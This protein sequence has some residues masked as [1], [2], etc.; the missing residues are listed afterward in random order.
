[1]ISAR[2][3]QHWNGFQYV[4]SPWALQWPRSR[5][6]LSDVVID[7]DQ[8]DDSNNDNNNTSTHD[9]HRT[10]MLRFIT[11]PMMLDY[12]FTADDTAENYNYSAFISWD[13]WDIDGIVDNCRS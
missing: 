11:A 9:N 1:M 5:Y 12:V 4:G 10:L 8:G 13:T 7:D 3:H 2:N 6:C